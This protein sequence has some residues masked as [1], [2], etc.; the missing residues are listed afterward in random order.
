MGNDTTIIRPLAA[1]DF[2]QV[3]QFLEIL[4]AECAVHDAMILAD[5]DLE[6]VAD[7]D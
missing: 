4:G 1:P 5:P 3:P 6:A 7:N 2:P